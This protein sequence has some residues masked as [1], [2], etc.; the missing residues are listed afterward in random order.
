MRDKHVQSQQKDIIVTALFQSTKFQQLNI[1]FT[2][3]IIFDCKRTSNVI[4]D[5]F[6]TLHKRLSVSPQTLSQCMLWCHPVSVLPRSRWE[7]NPCF[8]QH[9]T[10]PRTSDNT[11]HAVLEKVEDMLKDL[12]LSS[13]FYW[14]FQWLYGQHIVF[15]SEEVCT[16]LR[17]YAS[18]PLNLQCEFYT[19][20]QE[21]LKHDDGKLEHKDYCTLAECSIV[22]TTFVASLDTRS[23]A[24]PMPFTILP[25][26]THGTC[27]TKQVKT[28]CI[29]I[30]DDIII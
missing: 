3:W 4:L 12:F 17:F 24:P 8:Y 16:S 10:P 28:Y 7:L 26:E 29:F 15:Q 11:Q 14:P 30:S 21:M 25:W 27:Q 9:Q 2:E 6:C 23:I 19:Q 5:F 1:M 13:K 18:H 22:M 20:W